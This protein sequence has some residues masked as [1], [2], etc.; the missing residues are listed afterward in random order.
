MELIDT[1][2]HLTDGKFDSDLDSVLQRAAAA[3]VTRVIV[4]GYD[5]ESSEKAVRLSGEHGGIFASVGTHPHDASSYDLTVESRYEELAATAY[6][7]LRG[8]LPRSRT[9]VPSLR[10]RVSGACAHEVS[11]PTMLRGRLSRSVRQQVFGACAHEVSTPTVVAIGEIG[12]D[13]H[14]DFSPRPAQRAAFEAQ[15]ALAQR[16][17]MPVIIHSREAMEDT[18][19]ILRPFAGLL[20]GGVFHCFSGDAKEAAEVLDLGMHIGVDGPITFKSNTRLAEVVRMC[21]GERLLVETDC[22]YM[23]P[24]PYRGK[25]NEPAYLTRIVEEIAKIRGISLVEV[26]ESTTAAACALFRL[27]R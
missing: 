27:P 4:C 7:M 23:A 17:Q 22:P 11:T 21:P 24:H 19:S 13:Y 5:V 20:V 1:H 26:A 18:L 9:F 16:L 12:L 3:G 6:A 15:L 14:Y 10:Q 25:R 8:R 2:A